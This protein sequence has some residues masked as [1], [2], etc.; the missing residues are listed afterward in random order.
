MCWRQWPLTALVNHQGN[1]P[2]RTVT[3]ARHKTI[4]VSGT[5]NGR[6]RTVVRCP[7]ST[8]WVSPRWG[9]R[10]GPWLQQGHPPGRPHQ[11][12]LWLT[13]VEM[14]PIDLVGEA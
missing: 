13:R 1:S 11:I 3:D 6:K 7:V 2:G 10:P 14:R 8:C 5:G 9:S 12:R 4:A